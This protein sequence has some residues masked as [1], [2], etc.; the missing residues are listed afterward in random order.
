MKLFRSK[1]WFLTVL[2]TVLVAALPTKAQVTIGSM[3]P[4]KSFSI[5]ELISNESGLRLPQLDATKREDLKLQLSVLVG[6]TKESAKGL[7]I[8]NIETNCVEFWSG[9]DWISLCQPSTPSLSVGPSNLFF[10]FRGK[11]IQNVTVITSI[12]EGWTVDSKPAWIE[13]STENSTGISLSVNTTVNDGAEREGEIIIKA[14]TI[15]KTI[16]V[17]QFDETKMCGEGT[18]ADPFIILTPQQLDSVR[19]VLDAHYRVGRNID[20]TAYLAPGGAGYAKWNTAGWLPIGDASH[21]FTGSVDCEGYTISGLVIYRPAASFGAIGLFGV[22]EAGGSIKNMKV[23][24]DS[25]N[26]GVNT[27]VGGVAGRLHGDCSVIS[28]CSVT[29]SKIKNGRIMGGNSVGG[30]VGRVDLGNSIITGCYASV[31]VNGANG[32][33]GVV[34]QVGSDEKS[35]RGGSISNCY[36]TGNIR[37][38]TG[39]GGV[40]GRI[41]NRSHMRNCYATGSISRDQVSNANINYLGGVCGRLDNYG[42]IVNCVALNTS[43]ISTLNSNSV[44]GRITPNVG[45]ANSVIN[46]NY[47]RVMVLT[48]GTGNQ[49]TPL[50]ETHNGLDGALISPSEYNSESWWQTASNWNTTSPETAWDFTNVWKWDD[51][52]DLPILKWQ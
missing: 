50:D 40:A 31:D 22:V 25:I 49:K 21:P 9:E 17:K 44:I 23:E 2:A 51:D 47:S 27:H 35:E 28:N 34:G 41:Q 12:P 7:V 43:V 37:G 6:E 52:N 20:L 1:N 16:N 13:V 30:V 10:D 36:S 24:L 46:H 18:I 42:S 3:D 4:P 29:G 11:P 45:G 19:N 33:G 39:V 15:T 8:F 5:L 48:M 14:G 26:G 32:I 38:T